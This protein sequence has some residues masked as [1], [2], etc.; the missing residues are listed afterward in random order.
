MKFVLPFFPFSLLF[1]L[2]VIEQ[3]VMAE[4]VRSSNPVA[5]RHL[6]A[7]GASAV[8]A[9]QLYHCRKFWKSALSHLLSLFFSSF[10]LE[11]SPVPVREKS[12]GHRFSL[13]PI[14]LFWFPPVLLHG[15]S[16]D[17][18]GPVRAPVRRFSGRTSLSEPS[19]ITMDITIV[20]QEKERKKEKE[21]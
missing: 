2:L 18:I 4:A 11:S 19:L 7:G 8:A 1:K 10:F 9:W 13:K 16:V 15:R 12:P 17:W 20:A 21:K 3:R 14:E 6:T 5:A